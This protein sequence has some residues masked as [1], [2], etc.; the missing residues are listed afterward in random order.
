[1]RRA[2]TWVELLV[3]LTVIFLAVLLAMPVFL[4]VR[5]ATARARCLSHLR[6]LSDAMSL[7]ADANSATMP[8]SMPVRTGRWQ[9][10]AEATAEDSI[11]WANSINADRDDFACPILDNPSAFAYNGYL[12]ALPTSKTKNPK[13]TITIWEGFGKNPRNVSLPRLDCGEVAMP[14][15]YDVENIRTIAEAPEGP[16]W[17]HGRGA[18]FLFLD[19]H[20]SWRRL[21]ERDGTP[22]DPKVDPFHKYARSGHVDR[23]W[24]D[25][26]GRAPLFKP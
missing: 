25:D 5:E 17:T 3:I 10:N 13:S 15:G 21:G 11:Y 19:G 26:A 6:S 24:L 8:L 12:H 22:T 20:A 23:F 1:M 14:C 7:Y 18:N 16:A 9:P 2:F 4:H